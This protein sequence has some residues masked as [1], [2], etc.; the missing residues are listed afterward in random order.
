MSTTQRINKLVHLGIHDNVSE[1]VEDNDAD[2]KSRAAV[3][4]NNMASHRSPLEMLLDSPDI[5]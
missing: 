1:L 3:A 2:V 4:M 5:S